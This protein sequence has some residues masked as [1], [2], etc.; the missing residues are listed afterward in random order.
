MMNKNKIILLFD[1]ILK[2]Q[3]TILDFEEP[4]K[5]VK[6]RCVAEYYREIADKYDEIA[7]LYMEITK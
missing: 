2:L 5:V 1:E 6:C 3:D 7:D 4:D